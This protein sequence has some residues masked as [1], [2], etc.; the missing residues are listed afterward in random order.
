MDSEKLFCLN[1][2]LK[3][4]YYKHISVLNP[5]KALKV[6]L[7]EFLAREMIP[8][9]RK[10]DTLFD[11]MYNGYYHQSSYINGSRINNRYEYDLILSMKLPLKGDPNVD[12]ND[13][14]CDP[15]YAT[16]SIRGDIKDALASNASDLAQAMKDVLL[17]KSTDGWKVG[18]GRTRQWIYSI[19]LKLTNDQEFKKMLSQQG[20]KS[21]RVKG[22]KTSG[23]ATTLE[24]DLDN[25]AIIDVDIVP[26]FEFK[27]QQILHLSTVGKLLKPY[28]ASNLPKDYQDFGGIAKY[29]TF[30]IYDANIPKPKQIMN[31]SQW[32]LDLIEMEKRILY[33]N[34]C[35][36]MVVELLECFR[37]SNSEIQFLSNYI[38]KTVVMLI[39][40]EHPTYRWEEKYL[41]AYFLLGLQTLLVKLEEKKLS[42]HFHPGSNI[43]GYISSSSIQKMVFWL[44]KTLK[45]LNTSYD[46]KR[47]THLWFQYFA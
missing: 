12:F 27:C 14:R 15:G 47:L 24:I 3:D 42:F 40:K 39:I 20:I 30:C 38:L 11:A 8:L 25:E 43:I 7:V 35:A 32:R 29:D 2:V 22:L 45:I 17:L 26:T 6:K 19:A 44:R 21:I 10:K 46:D 9:M 37:D 4:I 18:P 5:E 31:K 36:K 41:A 13:D 23:L 16:C 34:G 1:E 33:E 28:W